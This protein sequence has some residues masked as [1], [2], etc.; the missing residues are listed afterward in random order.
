MN[1]IPNRCYICNSK[2]RSFCP[3]AN[4]VICSAC[5]GSRRGTEINCGPDCEHFP[6]SVKG[7]DLWLK[8]DTNLARKIFTYV[9]N[10]CGKD[11]FEK[12]MDHMSFKGKGDDSEIAVTA[13]GSAVFNI[14]FVEKGAD[15]QTLAQ[16]WKSSGW[17]GLTNDER[18]MMDCRMSSRATI[19][20]IQKILD[21]QMMECIDLL[22]TA[23]GK[24]ILLD[25]NTA[26]RAV[27]F[28]RLFTWFTHYP[29]FS[30]PENNG[31]EIPDSIFAEFM[32]LA[33]QKFTRE[34]K[35]R[36]GLTLKDYL[37][38]DFG[39]FC[40]LIY[41]L[42]RDKSVAALERMDFHQCKAVYRI[43]GKFDEI[44]TILD[45]YPDFRARERNTDEE[46]MEGA[47]YYSWMRRGE[48][49]SL[50]KEMIAAFQHDDESQGVGV[51]GNV[52]L[53]PGMIIMEVFSRQK[54]EFAKK[55]FK[56][57]FNKAIALQ[58]EMVVDLAKKLA[59]KIEN[60]D[61]FP[62]ISLAEAPETR[63]DPIP[64][65]VERKLLQDF[66][67]TRYE[68]F[69]DEQI[70]ALNNM[71]P[72]QAAK[73]PRMRTMLIDL[74]KIHLKGIEKQNKEKDLGINIDKVLEELHLKELI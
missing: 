56:K 65:E 43:E 68:N 48:S 15:G 58:K 44:K 38:E 7:Y 17:N 26:A 23:R 69:M 2:G 63:S 51:M 73:D 6:F 70:P 20:E 24:V 33:E 41:E 45:T 74:M 34:S 62:G 30:R 14:L 28:T 27:R 53:C 54:F 35:K 1:T 5:C 11:Y 39:V 10:V 52:T 67:K 57:Y 13:A 49:K 29:Y 19:I 60:D 64:A 61:E 18:R 21:N 71:T 40:G 8:T 50:E 36:P 3:T 59:G 37:S 72:R 42:A 32:E 4:K 31:V 25:R 47:F 16:R 9:I 46:P 55:I 66:Y 12:M 22:D